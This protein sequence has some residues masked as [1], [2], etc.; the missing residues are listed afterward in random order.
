MDIESIDL[1]LEEL[2][3][4]QNVVN[5]RIAKLEEDRRSMRSRQFIGKHLITTNDI[6]F[7]EGD[8]VPRFNDVFGFGEWMK[9]KGCQKRFYEWN[10]MICVTSELMNGVH[11]SVA[12]VSDVE[13]HERESA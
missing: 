6:Q 7:S 11:D 1:A 10:T 5:S 13:R 3:L 12:R 8:G 9:E 2:E 4:I